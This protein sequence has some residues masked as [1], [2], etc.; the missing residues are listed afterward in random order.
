MVAK[1]PA[2]YQ[3]EISTNFDIM[4]KFN[5]TI[6][7]EVTREKLPQVFSSPFFDHEKVRNIKQRNKKSFLHLQRSGS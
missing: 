7:D 4:I 6:L 3:I 2:N 1:W 5:R